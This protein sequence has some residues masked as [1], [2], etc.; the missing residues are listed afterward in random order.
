M[1]FLIDKEYLINCFKTVVSVPSPVG[2]YVK[3]KPVLECLAAEQGRKITYDNR[4]T[5]Y[6]YLEGENRSKKVLIGAH[7]D[8]LG[9]AV[10]GIDS[11]GQLLLRRLGGGC[12]PSVEGESVT[13]HTRDGREYTGLIICTSHSTHVFDDAHTLE[14]NENTIR[15]LLDEDVHSKQDVKALGIQNGDF[16]SVE[17]RAQITEN[18]YLKSRYIDDKGGIACCFAALKYLNDNRLKPKYDSIFAF[19]YYEE[20]GLGGTFVPTGVSEYVAVDIG[21]IGPELDGDERKVSICAKDAATPY[22]IELTNRLIKLAKKAECDYALDVFYRYGTDASAAMRA[23]NDL[24]IGAF[25]MAVYCSHGRER[26]HID[27]LSATAELL[28]AYMLD[29]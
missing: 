3:L 5:A 21:L 16:V 27:G 11:N 9:F 13:V 15:V 22:D 12:I 6:I 26:T 8:T 7:A 10:R 2:Y 28:L 18:G 29:I 1:K 24:R 25:G 14:R 17:P 19:P 23:G 4:N 20:L